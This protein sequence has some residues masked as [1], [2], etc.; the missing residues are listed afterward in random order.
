MIV[1]TRASQAASR[2]RIPAFEVWAWTMWG[3]DLRR[4]CNIEKKALRSFQ[5]EIRRT[6]EGRSITS[7]SCF[8]AVANWSFTSWSSGTVIA[9]SR[10][11]PLTIHTLY[12]CGSW[13]KAASRVFCAEP[14]MSR[15]VMIW[16]ILVFLCKISFLQEGERDLKKD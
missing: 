3:F 14:P 1:G 16:I 13:F 4:S 6:R 5:G 11:E 9:D 15:R 7:T 10:V 12:R 2:P 8:S